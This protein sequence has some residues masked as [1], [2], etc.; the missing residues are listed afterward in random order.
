[1]QKII[2]GDFF[3]MKEDIRKEIVP[4]EG[5][6]IELSESVLKVKGPKSEVERKFVHPKIKLTI[7]G[8]KVVLL[9]LKATKREKTIIGSFEAHI[10]NMVKGVIEPHIYKLKICSGHFPMNVSVSGQDLIIKNFL[11]ESVPRKIT[12]KEGV[13]VKVNGTEI[14]VISADKELAGQTAAKIETLCRI[15]NRDRR[16]FQDGCYITLKAGKEI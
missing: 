12:F 9:A 11:G 14:D 6:Q 3:S 4:E 10:K 15:T 1:M 16:I 2:E 5:V 7:E 8:G 13:S